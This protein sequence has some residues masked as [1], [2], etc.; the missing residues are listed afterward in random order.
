VVIMSTINVRYFIE[1]DQ[2]PHWCKLNESLIIKLVDDFQRWPELRSDS[3]GE[4]DIEGEQAERLVRFILYD[5]EQSRNDILHLKNRHIAYNKRFSKSVSEVERQQH[6][7]DYSAELGSTAKQVRQDKKAF[8]RWFGHDAMNDRFQH[9][10]LSLERYLSFIL[11]FLGRITALA[12]EKQSQY[13]AYDNLWSRMNLEPVIAP[14]LRYEDDTRVVTSAFHALSHALRALPIDIQQQSMSEEVSRFV[15]HACLRGNQSV[16]VQTEALVLLQTIS[17]KSLAQVLRRRL[18]HPKS[19]DDLFVRRKIVLI[20]G[21]Q[22][23]SQPQLADLF[24]LLENDPSPA[25]R[26]KLPEILINAD[27]QLIENTFPK[28]LFDDESEHV[29]ASALLSLHYHLIQQRHGH[30]DIALNY[31]QQSLQ[32]EKDSF[33]LR[34]ALKVCKQS[35]ISIQQHNDAGNTQQ[36][37]STILPEIESLHS[38]ASSIAVRR[39]AAQTRDYL[40]VSCDVNL[41][42]R[43][44]E[45][46]AFTKTITP[47]KQRRL[48]KALMPDSEASLG[49]I[50]SVI[51][52]EDFGF[53]VQ[54]GLFGCYITRGHVF[55]FRLWRLIH[56]FRHPFSEKREAFS[57]TRGRLFW[58]SMRIPSG[59]LSELAETK[60]PGEPLFNEDEEGWR[61]YI[62]LVDEVLSSLSLGRITTFYHSEG[63]VEMTPPSNWF[64]RRYAAFKISWHFAEYAQMRNWQEG[65]QDP[66]DRYIT[67]LADMGIKV[68]YA[69]HSSEQNSISEDPYVQRFFPATFPLSFSSADLQT[70]QEFKDYFV[71]VYENSLYELVAFMT[72][73]VMYFLIKHVISYRQ[74]RQSRDRIPL[75]IGGWGT[76][77]KSGTERIKAALL[78]ALGYSMISKTTGCEAMFIHS[79]PFGPLRE[80]FLFRPYDK[81]TIWEQ[82]NLVRLADKLDSEV[83]LWECMGLTPSYI[84]ILQRQW[85]RDDIATITNT[86]PDHENLQG[87]AGV[88]I[89]EVMTEFIPVKSQLITSEEQMRPILEVAAGQLNTQFRHVGW[90]EAGLLTKDVL[91]R[92]PYDE[93]P[94]NIALV[95]AMGDELGIEGDYALKEMA[96][97]VV[98]DIGVLKTYP[99]SSIDSRRIEFINGMSAN[100]RFGCLG[101]WSRMGLDTISNEEEPNTWISI[102]INNRADRAA[103]SLVFASIIV[104]DLSF[105]RC[106]LI[107]NNLSGFSAYV[108]DAWQEWV[109]TIHLTS[110]DET[111]KDILL[112][113]AKHFRIPYSLALR[114]KRAGLMLKAQSSSLEIDSLLSNIER[115]E[116]LEK[117]LEEHEVSNAKDLSDHLSQDHVLMTSYQLFDAKLIQNIEISPQLQQEFEQLLWQ[118]FESKIVIEDD[119]YAAGNQVIKRIVSATPPGFYNRVMGMQNIKGTGLDFVYS[120]QAWETCFKACQQLLSSSPSESLIGLRALS[121]FQDYGHLSAEMVQETI[122]LA[123]DSSMAQTEHY[124]AELGLITSN[125]ERALD[126]LNNVQDQG[127]QVDSWADK[128]NNALE[129]FFDAGDAVKRRKKADLIYQDLIVERISYERAAIELKAIN[130]RQKGGWLNIFK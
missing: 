123:K 40:L 102:V 47:G 51:A 45:L 81:A 111:P 105:D 121:A 59:I 8:S 127:V 52:Q 22:L 114:N 3:V 65:G 42:K 76:R 126:S 103:R 88:N 82:H 60:V 78:N 6:I 34:V 67:A 63:I 128:A 106:I 20:I 99:C 69:G 4:S 83:F 12:L 120:W 129:D 58:G 79:H 23:S 130:K 118:W 41:H 57:H 14:L 19:D 50:L 16:W 26:Q 48:P 124:Q 89:P 77:G 35:F 84:H 98:A 32:T 38:N 44:D 73:I 109:T 15:Y 9:H 5:I 125:L 7:L 75:V 18:E 80:M 107:G 25:V 36:F 46:T 61:G 110:P 93:H 119:Y 17:P 10:F 108:K 104:K 24:P 37:I 64:K 87:P 74:M 39:W 117:L 101:N 28:L 68:S 112:R 71:S 27:L 56:E 2:H 54:L 43:L 13:I 53:D 29:R 70:W 90:L 49:R 66:A 116:E 1:L 97:R 91:D 31:L 115:P 94:Y 86:Y 33:A 85:M 100:E 96:D 122:A 92:F 95:M 55:G 21:E 72:V 113:M 11:N 62:P 30:F